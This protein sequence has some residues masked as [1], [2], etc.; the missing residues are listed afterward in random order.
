MHAII[1]LAL[2]APPAD[3][4]QTHDL[5]TMTWQR[6]KALEG[7]RVRVRFTPDWVEGKGGP[8]PGPYGDEVTVSVVGPETECRFA[9]LPKRDETAVVKG[10][11]MEAEGVLQVTWRC[12]DP[13]Y[14]ALELKV[15]RL[16]R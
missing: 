3:A 10:V 9:T 12:G 15:A 7:Q 8:V 4:V 5:G 6:A 2:A 1:L 16:V 14:F 13:G 11:R